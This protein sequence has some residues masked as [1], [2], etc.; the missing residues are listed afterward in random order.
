MGTAL[1][2]ILSLAGT[3]LLFLAVRTRMPRTLV[4]AIAGVGIPLV[5][6]PIAAYGVGALP[7]LVLA[8]ALGIKEG[9]HELLRFVDTLRRPKAA[10]TESPV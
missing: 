8:A 4:L 7:A 3:F 10:E 2:Q 5:L 6:V 9:R 1:G